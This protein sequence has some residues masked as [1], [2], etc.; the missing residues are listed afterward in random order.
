MLHG[1]AYECDRFPTDTARYLQAEHGLEVHPETIRRWAR[2]GQWGEVADAALRELAPDLNAAA[3]ALLVRA[4][5]LARRTLVAIMAHINPAKVSMP[6]VAAL[7]TLLAE[8]Q[9]AQAPADHAGAIDTSKMSMP[10]LMQQLRDRPDADKAG[11][12]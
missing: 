8:T 2:T 7:Q 11:Q 5:P 10:E 4:K 3:D 12:R 1:W 6:E 9:R